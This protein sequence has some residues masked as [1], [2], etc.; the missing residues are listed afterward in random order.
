MAIFIPYVKATVIAATVGKY[1]A[2]AIALYA[3]FTLQLTLLLL[4]GFVFVA[5]QAEKIQV[6]LGERKKNGQQG[7]E[8]FGQ[9]QNPL[10]GQPDQHTFGQ[11]T[12]QTQQASGSMPGDQTQIN[13]PSTLDIQGVVTWLTNVKA[14]CCN[15]VESGK[16]IGRISRAQLLSALS[17]G[18]GTL[19]VGQLMRQR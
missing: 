18:M 14:E 15:I 10:G 7:W 6:L 13:I 5:G 1:C 3:V 9:N 17:D 4:A 16:V 19:P 11:P 12:Y 2:I 8:P